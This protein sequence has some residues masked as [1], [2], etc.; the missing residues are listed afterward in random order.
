MRR[1]D[2]SLIVSFLIIVSLTVLAAPA[3]WGQEV[4]ADKAKELLQQGISQYQAMDFKSAQASLL[5]AY[6]ARD[7]LSKEDQDKLDQLLSQVNV[8]IKKQA[9]DAEALEAARKAVGDGDLEAAVGLFD[10][11]LKSEYLPEQ[12]KK[13]ARAERAMALEKAKAAKAASGPAKAPAPVAAPPAAPPLAAETPTAVETT[14]TAGAVA[15]QPTPASAEGE[16][17]IQELQVRLKKARDLIAKG[18]AALKKDGVDEALALYQQACEL[19]PESQEAL[20]ALARARSYLDQQTDASPLTRL[21]RIRQVQKQEVGVRYEQSVT[22]AREAI[23]SPKTEE[24]FDR[25]TALVSVAETQLATNRNLFTDAEYREKRVELDKLGEYVLSAREQWRKRQVAVQA[26][27]IEKRTQELNREREQ[28][29]AE[30]IATLK[31]SVRQKRDEEKYEEAV[32]ILDRIRVLDPKDAW[33]EE[34]HNQLTRF[35]W[36]MKARD[37]HK[38]GLRE[39]VKQL[40]DVREA[41]IPWYELLRYPRDWPEITLRRMAGS[42][43]ELAESEANRLVRKRL[44]QTL[45]KLEF[46]GIAFEDVVQFLR[47]VSNTNIYVN[48]GALTAVGIDR[49]TPVN[50]KLTDVTFEKALRTILDDVGGVNPLGYVLDEGVITISTKDDLAKKTLV[51]TYDIRDLIIR[52]PNFAGPQIDI[53]ANTNNAGN[54]GNNGGGSSGGL[55]GN[56]ASGGGNNGN[57]AGSE[58]NLISRE[59]LVENIRTLIMDTI[60]RD[61]WVEN[62]GTVGSLKELSGQ[63]IVTQTAE[64]HQALIDLLNQLREARTLQINIEARF[65]TVSSSFLHNIGIDLD[66]YFTPGSKLAWT[67]PVPPLPGR[68]VLDPVTG[69]RLTHAGPQLGQWTGKRT[70]NNWSV[71]PVQQDSTTWAGPSATGRGMNIAGTAVPNAMNIAGTFLDDIQVDFLLNATEAH[72]STRMLQAPRITIFNGQ[73]AYITVAS[74]T[75]YVANVDPVVSENVVAYRYTI[76]QVATGVVLDV[77]GTVSADRRYVT[78]TIR[79]TSSNILGFTEYQGTPGVVGSGTVQLPRIATQKLECTVSVPDG[80]TLLLGG[81]KEGGETE[82]EMGVPM[83]SKIPVLNRAFTN[84]SKV[85]DE[86]QLLILVKPSII[87]QREYEEAS[88][89]PAS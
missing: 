48:W 72:A 36:L 89:P 53:A 49:K 26:G 65:I 8:A 76:G 51:R 42:V 30:K 71:V 37:Y 59:Q 11:V 41:Q 61:S 40:V 31:A 84:K 79:P 70:A 20:Q 9:E 16:V 66:F 19:A 33:A 1:I 14:E 69:A 64:N 29:K 4:Q 28:Q 73:R 25:A 47:D 56:N 57:N 21:A 68:F 27:E 43:G 3:A 81:V 18:D 7:G 39:E 85:R 62:S 80:G 50:I 15:S 32:A 38:T 6:E 82:R 78:L 17:A 86:Q 77:E 54:A 46:V 67:A 63:L 34:W 35:M 2:F 5:Q 45:P 74:M 13:A 12:T 88:F 58:E 87:I 60:A 24:D 44:R 83:I 23:Q 75:A 22:R 55:F 52:V 10:R